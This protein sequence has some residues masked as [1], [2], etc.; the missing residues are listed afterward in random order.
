MAEMTE[1]DA[2]KVRYADKQTAL[3]NSQQVEAQAFA[4]IRGLVDGT[5]DRSRVTVSDT[6]WTVTPV[7]QAEATAIANNATEV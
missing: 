1:L 2:L 4:L 6:G 5:V 3:E 7:V